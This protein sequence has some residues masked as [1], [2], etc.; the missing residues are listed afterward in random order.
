MLEV[1]TKVNVNNPKT[2]SKEWK[3]CSGVVSQILTTIN[4]DSNK[5]RNVY[6]VTK[7]NGASSP[8]EIQYL[9]EA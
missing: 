7:D 5:E 1:G 3:S 8:V 4:A 9:T 2:Q 6:I